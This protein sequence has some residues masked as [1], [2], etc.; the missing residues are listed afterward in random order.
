[1]PQPTALFSA[2]DL[3]ET[4]AVADVLYLARAAG[5]QRR[6]QWPGTIG[7][8]ATKEHSAVS[9]QQSENRSFLQSVIDCLFIGRSTHR[10]DVLQRLNVEC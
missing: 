3:Q 10:R 6:S 1:M 5:E 7:T 4:G 2:L 8:A 9:T